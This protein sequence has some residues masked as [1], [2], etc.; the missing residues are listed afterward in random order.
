M[1]DA[2]DELV[3]VGGVSLVDADEPFEKA[4]ELVKVSQ[5]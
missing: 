5:S 4:I 3:A 2:G 1:L